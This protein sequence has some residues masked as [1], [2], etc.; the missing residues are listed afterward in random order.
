MKRAMRIFLSFVFPLFSSKCVFA[1]DF[2]ENAEKQQNF[3]KFFFTAQTEEICAR[4]KDTYLFETRETFE[5]EK[6]ERERENT[7]AATG[8]FYNNGKK[9]RKT[10]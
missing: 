9:K 3:E 10:I 5:R 6:R 2:L 7:R 1:F 4:N 8:H